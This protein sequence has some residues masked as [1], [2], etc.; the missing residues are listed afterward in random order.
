MKDFKIKLKKI[1]VDNLLAM[2][3]SFAMYVGGDYLM[4][5]NVMPNL[6]G[7]WFFMFFIG[8]AIF[9]YNLTVIIKV[10]HLGYHIKRDIKDLSDGKID[11]KQNEKPL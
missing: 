9:M 2:I 6:K 4:A 7:L 10:D 8:F 5:T 1:I 11:G 3:V